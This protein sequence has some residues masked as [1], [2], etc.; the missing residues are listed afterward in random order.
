MK[1][2]QNVLDI[3][4]V[5]PFPENAYGINSETVEP[6]LGLGYLAAVAEERDF[7]CEIIDANILELKIAQVLRIIKQKKPKIVGINVNLYSYKV[8]LKLADKIKKALPKTT[9][10]LGGPTPT[11]APRQVMKACKT[12]AV[13]IGEGENTLTEILDNYKQGKHLFRSV[14]GM[15]YRSSSGKRIMN[16][17]P[18]AFI[19]NI[20]TI[21]FPAYHLFPDLNKYKSRAVKKPFA[22]LLTSRGCPFQCVFCSKDVFKYACRMRSPENVIDEIDMLVK[23]FGVKQ[24]DILDDNF[25]INKK[26]TERI[27]DLIIKRKYDLHINLQSGVRTEGIDT[28]IIRKMKKAKIFKI[29]FGVESGDP[30][31]LKRI[32]KQLNLKKVLAC[33]KMAKKAGMKVYGFF[34]IGLPGDTAESMQKTIDF[35]IK[36]NPNIA[37]FSITIPFPGTELYQTVKKEGKFLVDMD[38]GI[39][40][41]FYANKVF[42]ELEGMDKDVV[43]SYYQKAMKS[44]YFRPKKIFELIMSMNSW[45]E[46]QWFAKT[47]FSV[48]KKLFS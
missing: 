13:C 44:F 21:P 32:K 15:M 5:N 25:T 26:R 28:K 33:T 14:A 31:I 12:D 17:K 40:A 36:M 9:V 4:F 37:N 41:G 23:K 7:S 3:I 45:S 30:L 19:R 39:D 29:P 43:L 11:S 47:S 48:F 24:L 6:P 8:A 35:A 46:F 1:A 20:D 2:T 18:R 42:Y 34:M 10:I 22:P 16:N 27:L 38:N